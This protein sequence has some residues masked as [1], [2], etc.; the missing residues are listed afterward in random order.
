MRT[1]SHYQSNKRLF[2][3]RVITFHGR[4]KGASDFCDNHQQIIDS[5]SENLKIPEK[6]RQVLVW[7]HA[8]KSRNSEIGKLEKAMGTKL[9]FLLMLVVYQKG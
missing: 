7:R 5:I 3:S 8:I 2:F 6:L 1:I 4:V 9:V